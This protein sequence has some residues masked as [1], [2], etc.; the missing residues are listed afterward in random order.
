MAKKKIELPATSEEKIKEAARK[1]FMRKGYAA[2]RTRDIAEEA[3]INLALLN[4]YFRS[5]ERLFEEI[6][7]EKV[8]KLLGSLTPIMND[9]STSLNEKID[10]IVS[11]YLDVLA[12][13]PDLPVFVLNE[14]R[15]NNLSMLQNAHLDKLVAQSSFIKQLREKRSDVNPVHFLIS[16]LSMII[17]PFVARPM[18]FLTGMANE[19]TFGPLMNERRKLIPVWA[20]AMLKVK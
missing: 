20:K 9:D 18:L 10:S 1:V 13:N 6:M 14:L 7:Q 16:I 15:R 4:Y 3:G 12:A 19:K 11:S 8:Q 5:K 17:F 2:T